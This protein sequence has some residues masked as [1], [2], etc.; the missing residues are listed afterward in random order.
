MSCFSVTAEIVVDV[1]P[2]V[3]GVALEEVVCVEFVAETVEL[4]SGFSLV[5]V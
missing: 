5:V 4:T 2:N 3:P 1:S